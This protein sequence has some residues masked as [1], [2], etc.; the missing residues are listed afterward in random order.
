MRIRLLCRVTALAVAFGLLG[1]W[2]GTS[3]AENPWGRPNGWHFNLQLIAVPKGKSV[4]GTD[5]QGRRIFVKLDGKTRILL[6][7]GPFEVVDFN[8]TDGQAAFKLP[9]NPCLDPVTGAPLVDPV[10]GA[11]TTCPVDAPA[12][13]CYSVWIAELGK[14][15]NPSN[16]KCSA[17]MALC[18]NN[19]TCNSGFCSL[20]G[21]ACTVD[22]DCGVCSLDTLPL[23]RTTDRPKWRDATRQLT[24][25][26]LDLQIGG[27]GCDTR[28]PLFADDF[29]DYFWSIDNTGLRHA[30]IRFYPEAGDVC[31]VKS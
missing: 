17:V 5:S 18:G 30:Q 7:E 22:I 27:S 19:Q 25:I 8:G 11:P 14:P 16:D 31:G 26:C 24:T 23:E 9:A 15:C 13:Q 12:F 6:S 10:T 4:D 21:L 29:V 1:L 2:P 3:Q 20:S 28:I